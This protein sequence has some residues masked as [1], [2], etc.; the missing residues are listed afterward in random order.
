MKR[1]LQ[2]TIFTLTAGVCSAQDASLIWANL[3]AGPD[4]QKS[5]AINQD[6]FGNI[7]SAGYFQGI[8]DLN[9]GAGSN[10]MSSNGSKDAYVAK[11]FDDGSHAWSVS[12]GGSG[13]EIIHDVATDN[14]GNVICVG[15]Y[16]STSFDIDPGSNTIELTQ[17]SSSVSGFILKLDSNGNYMWSI[18][19]PCAS[20]Y[21][22]AVPTAVVVDDNGNV[23][24]AGTLTLMAGSSPV[25]FNPGAGDNSLGVAY[26]AFVA[27]YT[28]SGNYANV[29]GFEGYNAYEV[30]ISDLMIDD[31]SNIYINGYHFSIFD[32]NPAAGDYEINANGTN[33][34]F[35]CKLNSAG[36]F[37]WVQSWNDNESN[38]LSTGMR[39]DN[40]GN[41]YMTGSFASTMDFNPDLTSSYELINNTSYAQAYL[42]KLDNNGGFIYAKNVASGT[43]AISND[44]AFDND[45]NVYVIGQTA[46][47]ADLNPDDG[48]ALQYTAIGGSDVFITKLDED[49]N[50]IY[51]NQVGGTN[52]DEGNAIVYDPISNTFTATGAF[53]GSMDVDPGE[54]T[55]TLS[56]AGQMDAFVIRY[57]ECPVIESSFSATG[58]GNYIWNEQVYTLDGLY[59]QTFLSA[60]GCDSTV[61]LNLNIASSTSSNLIAEACTV[62]SIGDQELTESGDYIITL[63]N[64]EGCD[65]LVYL[66]LTI[67]ENP[68]LE[69]TV[70]GNEI[71][72]TSNSSQIQW[73]NCDD[74][75]MIEGATSASFSPGESGNFGVIVSNGP[76]TMEDCIEFTYIG[77]SDFAMLTFS[78]FPN[79]ADEQ[80]VVA[81]NLASCTLSIYSIE[82]KL[83]YESLSTSNTEHINI[84]SLKSGIYQLRLTAPDGTMQHQQFIKN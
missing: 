9:P 71:Q 16:S 3:Y 33:D 42:V 53:Y 54:E 30:V 77:V 51:S 50:F 84:A 18:A 34:S 31:A 26:R 39:M 68:T 55:N 61:T 28:S 75:V 10:V 35:I 82:G 48:A 24:I 60:S 1:F 58:C 76:C 40:A 4:M 78:I 7:I 17:S 36:T 69:L 5:L 23:M 64:M 14:L 47:I 25:D 73:Y 38:V 46:G 6:P 67:L 11:L 41:I 52:Y 2:F 12:F 49:G 19:L 8:S 79:P 62:Y 44:I 21:T 29:I 74:E 59:T 15:S 57:G 37:Q 22:S 43:S 70:N 80:L 20:A 63:E 65:S 81:G 27:T 72:C 32:F 13:D 45:N 66:E 83:V 56:S